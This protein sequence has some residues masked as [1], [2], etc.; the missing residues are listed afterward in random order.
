[1]ITI[2]KGWLFHGSALMLLEKRNQKLENITNTEIEIDEVEQQL[3]LI[4]QL[5]Q[6]V[7]ALYEQD[8]TD[9]ESDEEASLPL[10]ITLLADLEKL[11]AGIAIELPLHTALWLIR[12]RFARPVGNMTAAPDLIVDEE[13]LEDA[14]LSHTIRVRQTP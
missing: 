9:E 1:V 6:Q 2:I 5:E 11:P 14:G 8:T 4:Q 3:Q 12:A 13:Q 10:L 7:L